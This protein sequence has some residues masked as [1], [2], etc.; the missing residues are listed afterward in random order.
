M[1]PRRAMQG[2]SRSAFNVATIPV[3]AILLRPIWMRVQDL[4]GQMS[5]V[6]QENLTGQRVVKAF[7]RTEFEQQKFDAKVDALFTESYRTAKFQA[8]NDPFMQSLW[9]VSLAIVFWVSMQE[10]QAGNMNVGDVVAFQLYLTLRQVPVRTVGF[11]VNTFARANSGGARI[12]EILDA[13]SAVQERPGA[14]ALEGV[15]HRRLMIAG[16]FPGLLAE[17]QEGSDGALPEAGAGEHLDLN[18]GRVGEARGDARATR[19]LND[20]HGLGGGVALGA[21]G[22]ELGHAGVSSQPAIL[23]CLSPN[24]RSALKWIMQRRSAS[25]SASRCTAKRCSNTCSASRCAA[26]EFDAPSAVVLSVVWET[27]GA[28]VKRFLQTGGFG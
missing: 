1:S 6:L 7:S 26:I 20:H 19:A 8:F 12:F 10:V 9:L 28:E 17:A 11:I 4:Q 21:L 15:G 16:L 14:T 3:S 25:R 13:E 5:T 22:I 27:G 23:S 2:P 24:S 18:Y